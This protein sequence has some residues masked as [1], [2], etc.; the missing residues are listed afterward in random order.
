VN[1]L[2]LPANSHTQQIQFAD[3]QLIGDYDLTYTLPGN[4]AD[5]RATVTATGH[6]TLINM[7]KVFLFIVLPL[8]VLILL[9]LLRTWRKRQDRKYRSRVREEA[10]REARAALER[11]AAEA[12]GAGPQGPSGGGPRSGTIR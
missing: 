4:D 7:Q 5:G 9:L 3:V 11:E 8:L 12:R 1:V 10:M 6:I 2:V